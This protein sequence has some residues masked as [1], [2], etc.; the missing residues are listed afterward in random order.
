MT[1]GI[2]TLAYLDTEN[3]T[4][5]F[6]QGTA[7]QVLVSQGTTD[8]PQWKTLEI[9]D[10]DQLS[11]TLDGFALSTHTHSLLDIDDDIPT[12]ILYGNGTSIEGI[13]E[14]DATNK[15][16]KKI[17]GGY[18]WVAASDIT[19]D[20][21]PL[22][23]GTM[24]G[25]I[26]SN[27]INSKYRYYG[28]CSGASYV[29][30]RKNYLIRTRIPF[31]TQTG[32]I[33]DEND[34]FVI[35]IHG[36]D[37]DDSRNTIDCEIYLTPD[38]PGETWF[39]NRNY[40]NRGRVD[41]SSVKVYAPDTNNTENGTSYPSIEIEFTTALK[42]YITVDLIAY[43]ATVG[44]TC[45]NYNKLKGWTVESFTNNDVDIKPA[46]D[47]TSNY[48]ELTPISDTVGTHYHSILTLLTG[49]DNVTGKALIAGNDSNTNPN[50]GYLEG[51]KTQLTG[52]LCGNGTSV[53]NKANTSATKKFLAGQSGS[54]NFEIP[55]ISDIDGLS[56]AL[57]GKAPTAHASSATT[58]GISTATL[59]GHAKSA[60]SVPLVASGSGALGDQTAVFARENH[61]H[62]AQTEVHA[63]YQLMYPTSIM[64]T[65]GAT[66]E[67]VEFDGT[68]GYVQL[69]ITQLNPY[70]LGPNTLAAIGAAA[71][72]HTHS[73]A[74]SSSAGG[75]ANSVKEKLKIQL[76]GG[77][78][79][80][81]NGSAEKTINITASDVGAAASVHSHGI[82]S[83]K[84]GLS[85]VE[86]GRLLAT[87][88]EGADGSPNW[89]AK[90]NAG[91]YLKQTS[92]GV[93]WAPV[94]QRTFLKLNDSTTGIKT[95]GAGYTISMSA[96]ND[97]TV[98]I[99]CGTSE[100][101]EYDRYITLPSLSDLTEGDRIE[102]VLTN[103]SS[104]AIKLHY[105]YSKNDATLYRTHTNSNITQGERLIRSGQRMI[106]DVV[107]I[108]GTSKIWRITNISEFSNQ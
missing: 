25:P 38:T 1:T 46:Y 91:E 17:S 56:T 40:C 20:Y 102:I 19:G 36:Y 87:S 66:S 35:R 59:Y 52:I 50:W 26:E 16:L 43:N 72:S 41:I 31:T 34:P 55:G 86:V 75:A 67:A 42:A 27:I 29:E 30:A 61:V 47:T 94:H 54:Y 23:G 33:F 69:K 82:T 6:P 60:S 90:G 3:M 39:K 106:A 49:D 13:N 93:E 28:I 74:G 92:N 32:Y 81:Y 105:D 63:A 14:T 71:S 77:T 104:S 96:N 103:L 2:K 62:P 21:L 76:N 84:N 79:T 73:Y 44:S 9:S 78:P 5:R 83:L 11:T 65:G 80:E 107:I 89:L 108:S 53:S 88:T 97:L 45:P 22:A 7:G 8:K 57:A 10:I 70:M 4:Q 101:S 48:N 98:H 18:S 12:G 15:Y 37:L 58:Y 100:T 85:N 99:V 24:T 68:Q 51:I 95:S 64:V